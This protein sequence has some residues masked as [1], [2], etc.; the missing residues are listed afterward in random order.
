MVKPPV[1]G[2]TTI[3]SGRDWQELHLFLEVGNN[4]ECVSGVLSLGFSIVA[5]HQVAT[6]FC[7]DHNCG[8]VSLLL[9][10]GNCVQNVPMLWSKCSTGPSGL[11]LSSAVC[12]IGSKL[13]K[14]QQ[15]VL[16]V[17][18]LRVEAPLDQKG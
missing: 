12:S 17:C 3:R 14:N 8:M 15:A 16:C 1:T 7:Q 2:G 18:P 9:Y 4:A 13:R 6:F 5:H 10:K 11:V